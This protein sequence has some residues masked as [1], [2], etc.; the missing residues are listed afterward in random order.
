VRNTR[1]AMINIVIVVSVRVEDGED[2]ICRLGKKTAASGVS[3]SRWCSIGSL[4]ID[5]W[6]RKSSLKLDRPYLFRAESSRE[7]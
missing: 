6:D 1:R 3:S 4:N 7:C 2:E 5:R